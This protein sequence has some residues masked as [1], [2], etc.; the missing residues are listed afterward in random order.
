MLKNQEIKVPMLIKDLGMVYA[1]ETSKHKSRY[2]IFECPVCVK[3]YKTRTVDV[4]RG[5]STKCQSCKGTTHGLCKHRLYSVWSG[6]KK[7]CNNPKHTGYEH[8]GAR[9]I[10]VSEEFNDFAVWLKYVESLPDAYKDTYTIDRIDNDGDYERGN[11][12]W[13][14]KAV[15]VRNTRRIRS[16]N[17]SGYRGVSWHKS[18]NKWCTQ[19]R[20]NS[21][22]ISLGYYKTAIEAAKAY[23]S[24]VIK[25]NLEHT[26]NGVN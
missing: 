23:N 13:E 10:K 14:S 15:Q 16:S 1:K 2:G 6:E 7:R 20:V 12:R 4:T 24:Y 5:K 19:I 3:H 21:K 18:R 22:T 11:L 17:K 8:Y 25:N 26:L 9:G